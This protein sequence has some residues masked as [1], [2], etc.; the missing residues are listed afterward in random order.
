MVKLRIE[1][2]RKRK[3]MSMTEL[4]KGMNISTTAVSKWESGECQPTADKLP[5]LAALLGVGINELFTV[6][7]P[8]RLPETLS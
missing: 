4:A 2:F 3:H 5:Q 6:E 7:T 1:E 8:G